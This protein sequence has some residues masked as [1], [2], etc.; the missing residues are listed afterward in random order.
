MMNVVFLLQ[1]IAWPASVAACIWFLTKAA[2]EYARLAIA[3]YRDEQLLAATA[4]AARAL[5]ESKAAREEFA[6][7]KEAT[8]IEVQQLK[9]ALVQRSMS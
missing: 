8:E 7:A 3:Q 6:R 4:A 1:A 2:G 9:S 5:K